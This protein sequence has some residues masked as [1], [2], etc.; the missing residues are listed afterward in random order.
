M[1]IFVKTEHP[2][3]KGCDAVNKIKLFKEYFIIYFIGFFGY[4]LIELLWRGHT[5]WSMG[6]TGGICFITLY[7]LSKKRRGKNLTVTCLLGA[8]AITA[9]EFFSGYIV[10]IM[11]DWNVWD[12]SIMFGNI[13]GQVCILYSCLW[14]FLTIPVVF[15]S[16]YL[17]KKFI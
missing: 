8:A 14:Y 2:I 6:V 12:Y 1:H 9:I 13:W 11:L 3:F 10:N 17:Q 16:Y 4:M 5:H 15:F 7:L